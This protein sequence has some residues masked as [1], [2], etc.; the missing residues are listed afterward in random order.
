DSGVGGLTSVKEIINLLPGE[1]II[2]CGDN[3][4]APYG[5]RSADDI[6]SLTKKMLTF[7]T[8]KECQTSCC[9]M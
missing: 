5:N 4:N 6:I 9:R 8:V 7:F 1:D 2:Y 3:M